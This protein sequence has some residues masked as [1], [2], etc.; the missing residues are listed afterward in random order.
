MSLITQ[1]DNIE[2][3]NIYFSNPIKNNIKDN[4]LF[5]K[6]VYSDENIVL[7]NL[8]FKIKFNPLKVN[9]DNSRASISIENPSEII[10]TVYSVEKNILQQFNNYINASGDKRYT[11]YYSITDQVSSGTIRIYN[12]VNIH[13][14]TQINVLL[15]ISGV[16]VT[17]NNIGITYKFIYSNHL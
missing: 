6:L 3:N 12:V 16:W 9:I 10:D 8:Y 14:E 17:K 11:L 5:Y 13:H 15:K 7:K 1:H 2:Y 4:S